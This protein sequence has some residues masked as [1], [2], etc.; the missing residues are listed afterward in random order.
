MS[1]TDRERLSAAFEEAESSL[2]S[3]RPDSAATLKRGRR[4]LRT[5]R[6][7]TLAAAG[8]LFVALAGGGIAARAV[9]QGEE[10]AP[11]TTEPTTNGPDAE[12]PDDPED[13]PTTTTTTEP[14]LPPA[15]ENCGD[16]RSAPNVGT[17]IGVL[18]IV[19]TGVSC[20]EAV[21][22]AAEAEKQGGSSYESG[23]FACLAEFDDA[24]QPQNVYAC[25]RESDGAQITFVVRPEPA[26][27]LLE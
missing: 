2:P 13:D 23:G 3:L 18:N 25:L 21:R 7:A 22:V 9:L 15:P 14:P 6:L 16:I 12:P 1:A 19:A 26:D 10:S 11:T 8:T 20:D 24:A 27:P 17:E 4:L 5:R